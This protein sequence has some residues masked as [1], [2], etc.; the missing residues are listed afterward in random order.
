MCDSANGAA[1]EQ[2]KPSANNQIAFPFCDAACFILS[3][4]SGFHEVPSS[5]T[6]SMYVESAPARICQQL[7][8]LFLKL[9]FDDDDDDDSVRWPFPWIHSKKVI[10]SEW[11]PG[12]LTYWRMSRHNALI[13]VEECGHVH[14][15]MAKQWHSRSVALYGQNLNLQLVASGRQLDLADIFWAC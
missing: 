6:S 15:F 13:C 2:V 8:Q 10:R 4:A 12:N 9:L 5:W 11:R 7:M 3:A 1:L 14:N